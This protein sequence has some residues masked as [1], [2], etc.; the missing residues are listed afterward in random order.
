M[1]NFR[2]E[3]LESLLSELEEFEVEDR[4]YFHDLEPQALYDEALGGKIDALAHYCQ[5]LGWSELST[6]LQ[7]LLPLRGKA[8]SALDR[9]RMYVIPEIRHLMEQSDIDASLSSIDWFWDFVHPRIRA[10]ARPRFESGFFADAVEASFK[11]VNDSVKRI[12]REATKREADGAGLM[13]TAFSPVEPIILLSPMETESDRNIQQGYMHIFQ[14]AMIGIRNPK[15]HG[16]LNPDGKKALHLI[17][18]ASL[19]LCKIDERL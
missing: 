17:S 5:A 11:E 1:G 13:T 18:L 8:Y 15:A 9:V 7:D 16:N 14:G 10:L 4:D 12:F 3:A 6:Q 19:L 2:S